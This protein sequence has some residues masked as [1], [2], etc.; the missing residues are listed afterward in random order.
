MARRTHPTQLISD[1]HRISIALKNKRCTINCI[2]E[3]RGPMAR[4]TRL[5]LAVVVGIAVTMVEGLM[6]RFF[7]LVISRCFGYVTIRL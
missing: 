4:P 6:G 7:D 2:K 5:I 3:P 1:R